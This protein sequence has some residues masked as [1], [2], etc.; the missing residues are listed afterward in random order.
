LLKMYTDGASRIA[1]DQWEEGDVSC[2][3]PRR[4]ILPNSFYASDG[5]CETTLT[6][7]GEMGAYPTIIEKEVDK[8]LPFLATTEILNLA[9]KAGMGRE[10]AHKVIKKHAVAEVLEMR[11][12]GS[13]ENNFTRRLAMDSE[14][15]KYEI[16]RGDMDTIIG[17][18]KHFIGN[19]QKQIYDVVAKAKP[20][21]DKYSNEAKYTPQPIL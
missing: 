3:V 7:L 2:S 1:G 8:Y 5:L 10:E 9:I 15:K 4:V 18:R 20:L 19:A 12:L 6:V 21:L 17:Y 16:I 13:T 14:F 11:E